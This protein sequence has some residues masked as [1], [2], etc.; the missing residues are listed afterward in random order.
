MDLKRKLRDSP[1]NYYKGLK[2]GDIWEGYQT[3]TSG[4]G[5]LHEITEMNM[6][7]PLSIL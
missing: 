6:I 1:A 2:T 4:T 5:L 7:S 3:E